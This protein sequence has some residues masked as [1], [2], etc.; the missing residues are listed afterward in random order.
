M[1]SGSTAATSH[2]RLIIQMAAAARTGAPDLLGQRPQS[3]RSI[4][5]APDGAMELYPAIQFQVDEF[6]EDGE[7]CAFRLGRREVTEGAPLGYFFH[8]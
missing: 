6:R 7:L 1:R 5:V 4:A 3:R 2:R 8:I